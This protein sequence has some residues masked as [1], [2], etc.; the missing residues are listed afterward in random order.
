MALLPDP[1]TCVY[2]SGSFSGPRR[3]HEFLQIRC[4]QRRLLLL[5]HGAK[6]QPEGNCPVTRH[7]ASMKK[8][9]HH[10]IL[11]KDTKQCD[12][13]CCLSSRYILTHYK[14]CK[15]QRCPVCGPV[16]AKIR[17]HSGALV[18]TMPISMNLGT[19]LP[20]D[21]P[22]SMITQQSTLPSN[23]LRQDH[24]TLDHADMTPFDQPHSVPSAPPN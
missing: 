14:R 23:E 6:C 16:R 7:C 1:S 9:W 2:V 11:C 24:T 10:I 19:S 8:L 12:V 15:V 3:N 17:F 13:Q 21:V 5:Y 20:P 4:M 18:P 22:T